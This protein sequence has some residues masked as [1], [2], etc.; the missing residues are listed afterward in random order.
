MEIKSSIISMVSF[1]GRHIS[2][3]EKHYYKEEQRV[4][5]PSELTMMF[6]LAGFSEIKVYGCS[7]GHFAAQ[8]LRIDDIKMMIIGKQAEH[9]KYFLPLDEEG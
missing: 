3:M 1:I 5:I 6:R 4:Y 7:S 9:P 2:T 8:G